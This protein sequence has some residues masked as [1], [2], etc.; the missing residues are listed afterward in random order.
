MIS[1]P[2]P[3]RLEHVTVQYSPSVPPA[4]QNLSLVLQPGELLSIL[5]E[6][7]CGKTTLLRLIAGFEP[8][9]AGAVWLAGERV[10]GPGHWQPP[11]QRQVGMVFQDYALFPHLTVAA[12]IAFGL[13]SPSYQGDRTRK[14]ILAQVSAAI[15]QV[16]LTG[17]EKRYPHQ[18]SGGQQQRVALARALAPDPAL[19]LLDEPFSN[20]DVQVRQQLREDV[21][22]ILKQSGTSAILVTHDQEEALA[23][24]D[25][26]GVM[27]QGQLEQ[28]DTPE[29]IY[30]QPASQFVAAFVTQAN[31]L[32]ATWVD[33]YWQTELGAFAE[34]ASP[35]RD[36]GLMMIRQED[37]RLQS[38]PSGRFLVGDRQFLG[39]EYRYRLEAETGTTIY[40]RLP[41]MERFEIG[42]RVQ[43]DLTTA[44]PTVFFDHVA[45]QC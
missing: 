7:G 11:E 32:A 9:Q 23:F 39:R 45:L 40:A 6:S 26:V 37:I 33:S 31:F 4:I 34:N 20:L 12:N 25:R 36:R 14:S 41:T 35:E 8:P 29:V 16:K 42:D 1:R 3:L 38:S 2:D 28:L 24:A 44:K 21:R 15:A 30:Q 10:T 18:L 43:I 17:L 5:G 22:T 13:K 19:V 27:R